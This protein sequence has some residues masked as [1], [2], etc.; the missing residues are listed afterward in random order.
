MNDVFDESFPKNCKL[1]VLNRLTKG[2]EVTLSLNRL[3][4][5]DKRQIYYNETVHI[6]RLSCNLDVNIAEKRVHL[7]DSFFMAEN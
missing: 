5:L 3:S 6:C 7:I 4:S 2:C 1:I